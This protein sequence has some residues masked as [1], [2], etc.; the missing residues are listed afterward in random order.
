M[1]RV[2]EMLC[3]APGQLWRWVCGGFGDAFLP[4]LR[5]LKAI[6]LSSC[7]LTARAP[8]DPLQGK[9]RRTPCES[10]DYCRQ[11]QTAKVSAPGCNYRCSVFGPCAFDM[12]SL[13]LAVNLPSHADVKH[14]GCLPV[15]RPSHRTTGGPCFSFFDDA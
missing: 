7:W 3:V 9:Y 10:T 5:L 15:A 4:S 1:A 14:H 6:S 2:I 8:P 12:V 13:W 11:E